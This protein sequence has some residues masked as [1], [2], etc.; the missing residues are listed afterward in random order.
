MGRLRA[1]SQS[2]Q[3]TQTWSPGLWWNATM[4]STGNDLPQQ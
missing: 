2:M 3:V 1:S 4:F